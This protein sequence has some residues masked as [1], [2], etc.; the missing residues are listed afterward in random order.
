MGDTRTD[1]GQYYPGGRVVARHDVAPKQIV[2]KWSD[3]QEKPQIA[4]IPERYR[5]SDMKSKINEIASK[6]A[7]LV[8]AALIGW[9]ACA[10]VTVQKKRKDA[11]YNDDMVVVD[12]TGGGVDT[13]EVKE[14]VRELL[15]DGAARPLPKYLHALDFADSYTNDAAW[16]YAQPQPYGHC[17]AVRRGNT[18]SRN[19]DWK[20]DDAAEFV[21]RMAAGAGRFASVG[22]AN[23]GTN[24]TEQ[25]VTSGKWSRYY[26]CLP[27]RTVDGINE[28]G[29]V[30]EVNVVGGDPATNGWHTDGDIHP[31]A[32]VRW[33]LDN[34]KTAEDAATNLAARIA[35][36]EGWAQNFHY[37]IADKDETYIVENGEAHLV[38]S[39]SLA[40]AVLTNFRLYPTRDT[41]GE[42]QE[43]YDAL[44][45]GAEITSQWWTLTYTP[46]GYRASD[47]P[48]ITGE[49]LTQL[50]NY[51]DNNPREAHRGESIGG[52]SWWQTVHTSVYDIEN[53]TLRIAV[54]EIDNWYVFAI[55]TAG[56]VKPEAVKEIVE[57]MIG[58]ATNGT[59]RAATRLES[60]Y[61]A[62]GVD[63]SLGQNNQSNAYGIAIGRS[64]TVNG[65]NDNEQAIAIGRGAYA[66]MCTNAEGKAVKPALR[67]DA[68]VAI[69][70]KAKAYGQRGISIG[71]RTENYGIS[72]VA[73]GS[74]E[75]TQPDGDPWHLTIAS[76]DYTVAIGHNAQA[77]AKGA[78]Q[79]GWGTN[80]TANTLKFRGTTVVDA[81]G[82]IAY[83]E[84]DPQF[85]SWTNL[86]SLPLGPKA[87]T[88]GNV[89]AVAIGNAAETF[90]ADAFA[91]GS[92]ARVK[93]M[94]GTN[95]AISAGGAVQLG[96]GINNE[97]TS[98]QF[99]G[100]KIVNGQGKIPT[101]SLEAASTIGQIG[102]KADKSELNDYL[103]LSGGIMTGNVEA[104]GVVARSIDTD[105]NTLRVGNVKAAGSDSVVVG[106][107]GSHTTNSVAGIVIGPNTIVAAE[108]GIAIGGRNNDGRVGTGKVCRVTAS[109]AVQIGVGE[110]G[111]ANSLKF[112]NAA[113][114]VNTTIVSSH[115]K[116]PMASIDVDDA[117]GNLRYTITA[118]GGRFYFT[119]TEAINPRD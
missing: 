99:R 10:D 85:N 114:T 56:G 46:F 106:R 86:Y 59:V 13:N 77:L 51:W 82:K 43:R 17:S 32:A 62:I 70:S 67:G 50:F 57:P 54:Q 64:A 15:P 36:P 63:A 109:G 1:S 110:N 72:A 61:I 31:C 84:T 21:V 87:N 116:I 40:G 35:F 30:A 112:G 37:M 107:N 105:G 14:I 102:S 2:V 111:E 98:L 69:G 29:V 88:H 118:S 91:F 16:Y 83:V 78:A 115:G 34:A 95:V 26:K 97:R 22:V 74:A 6:F 101:A 90:N 25:F 20:F 52:E 18:L 48:G 38:P 4:P 44:M 93:V 100:T 80:T 66:G 76:N 71:Y 12:V 119:P 19:Y 42:G 3:V 7:T 24:L 49:A 11:L 94:D 27:G 113:G 104:K 60:P 89:N 79:I 45:D 33:A 103:K 75:P 96:N 117:P 53:K 47:L 8:V 9:S 58:D 108:Q 92:E 68:S 41:T 39:S 28:N 5:D 65:L 55:P 23:C 81:N 73:I